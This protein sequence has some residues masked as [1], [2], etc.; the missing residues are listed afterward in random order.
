MKS[1]QAKRALA[2]VLLCA[3]GLWLALPNPYRERTFL[4]DAG[5]CRLETTIV[6]KKEGVTAGSVV[7]LHGISANKKN[8]SY[9]ARGF[10]EQGFPGYVPDLAGHGRTPGPVSPA[11]AE[12]YP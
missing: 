1:R 6:E 4:I 7:L 10:A 12:K 2:G 8:M 3:A 9:I 5:G 11:P